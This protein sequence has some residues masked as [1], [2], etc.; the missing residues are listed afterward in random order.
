VICMI[1]EVDMP[2]Y[3]QRKRHR[4]RSRLLRSQIVR[5]QHGEVHEPRSFCARE[6]RLYDETLHEPRWSRSKLHNERWSPNGS[7]IVH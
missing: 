6:L 5:R 7:K 4:I 3:R 2:L 1:V